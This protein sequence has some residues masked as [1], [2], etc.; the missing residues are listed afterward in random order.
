M[1][2]FDREDGEPPLRRNICLDANILIRA[3]L[4]TRVLAIINTYAS[5]TTFAVADA[6]FAEARKHI[7]AIFANLGKPAGP[8]LDALEQLS[9]AVLRIDAE[10]YAPFR[11]QAQRRLQRRDPNDWPILALALAYDCP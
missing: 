2:S 4:G 6:A 9:S 11:R 3:V 8:A 7:P 5:V 10:R 1:A